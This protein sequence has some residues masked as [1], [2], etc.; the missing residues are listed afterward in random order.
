MTNSACSGKLPTTDAADKGRA[1][2]GLAQRHL[3]PELMDQPDADPHWH[4]HAL[5]ALEKVNRLSRTAAALWREIVRRVP[6][7]QLPKLRLLDVACGGGDVL[8][9]LARWAQDRGW[10]WHLA[11]CDISPRALQLAASQAQ[12][13]QVALELFEHDVL[14]RALPGAWDVITCTLFLHHLENSQAQ[15]LLADM[16]QAARRLV[17]VDDLNRTQ[18]G[19]WMAWLVGRISGNPLV[20]FDAPQSVRAAFRPQEVLHLARQAG[21][22]VLHIKTHWPQRW[23][24]ILQGTA[25]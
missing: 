2:P 8:I 4:R 11:G 10:Q 6:Q 16:I 20:R 23:L 1:V 18:L 5:R 7:E 14:V 3:E 12:Q 17:L 9:R 21:A 15:K 24:L 13:H 19:Y 25:C 22:E